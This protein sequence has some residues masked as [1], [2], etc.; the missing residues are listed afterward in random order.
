MEH[1]Q[2]IWGTK[3]MRNM[4]TKGIKAIREDKGGAMIEFALVFPLLLLLCLGATDFGRLFFNAVT[5]ANAAS[6][7]AFHGAQN[8]V[9]AAQSALMVTRA[10]QDANNLDGVN[11]T[12]ALFCECPGSPAAQVDCSLATDATACPGYGPPRAY[13]RTDLQ[14]TFNT[15]VNYPGIPAST[16]VRRTAFMRVQ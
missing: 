16:V 3:K 2:I 10:E 1:R 9:T 15:V 5:L 6:V 8:N 11:G 12:A 13:V 7:G 14:Q 4:I